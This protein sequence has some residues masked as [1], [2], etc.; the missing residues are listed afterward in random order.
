VPTLFCE[1]EGDIMS[2]DKR[3]P[4]VNLAQSETP[5]MLRTSMR[6]NRETPQVS[7]SNTSGRLKKATNYETS[8]KAGGESDE[9]VV[10]V[11]HSNKGERT[12]AESVEGSRSAK[13]NTEQTY[14]DR[15][16][17]RVNVSQGLGG[18]RQAARKDKKQKFTALLRHVTVD[19][20][21]ES[22]CS[23]KR[24]AVPGVDGVTWKQY[25]EG[26]EDR[27]AELHDRIHKG[28]YRALP[29]KRAYI[30]KADGGQRP[31]GMESNFNPKRFVL[32]VV[33][34]EFEGLLFGD[35][36]GFS[37]GIGQPALETAL[38]AVRDQFPTPEDIND[39]PLTAPSKHI[40]DLLPGY[41]KPL[42]DVLA[43][44]ETGLSC[45]RRECPH[46]DGWLARLASLVK[47]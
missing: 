38:Q 23:L 31:L 43:A 14:T 7:G 2:D 37:R 47:A 24:K 5:G 25:E 44:F 39:S 8:G 36:A 18:V 46:F 35:C 1:A 45:L 30:P 3:E 34:H 22:F 12:P 20:L 26:V 27:L 6:E 42:L 40:V 29:S 33:M 17:C 19:L 10:P 21:R 32:F 4:L 15:T 13:G 11:K 28:T 16:Q 9:R 41:E